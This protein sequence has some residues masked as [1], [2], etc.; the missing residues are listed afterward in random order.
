MNCVHA[1]IVFYRIAT[2]EDMTGVPKKPEVGFK[3]LRKS[4]S[5][6]TSSDYEIPITSGS[7]DSRK[8]V[9]NTTDSQ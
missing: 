7:M 1:H 5:G 6:V 2:Y 9:R 3:Y 8:Y 4:P